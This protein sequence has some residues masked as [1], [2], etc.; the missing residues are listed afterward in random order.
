MEL[1]INGSRREMAAGNI[2]DVIE[3]LGLTGKPVVVEAGGEVL[4]A[5]QWPCVKAVPGMTIEI[6]HFVGGG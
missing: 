2:A 6:V 1:I 3:K 4:V 5:E